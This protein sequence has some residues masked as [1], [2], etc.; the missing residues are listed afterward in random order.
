MASRETCQPRD[1][2]GQ[3]PIAAAIYRSSPYEYVVTADAIVQV[4]V[5]GESVTPVADVPRELVELPGF[6]FPARPAAA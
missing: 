5:V 2:M 1:A 4:F 6:D 3:D